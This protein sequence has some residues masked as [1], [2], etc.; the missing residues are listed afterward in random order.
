MDLTTMVGLLTID[1][2]HLTSTTRTTAEPTDLTI[3][4]VRVTTTS[5]AMPVRPALTEEMERTEQREWQLLNKRN[6]THPPT[7]VVLY[8]TAYAAAAF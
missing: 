3:M 1:D 7:C 8:S 2:L 6:L 5:Q 4:V